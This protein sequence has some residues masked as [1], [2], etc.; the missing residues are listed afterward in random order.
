M[1]NLVTYPSLHRPNGKWSRLF[2][3]LAVMALVAGLFPGFTSRAQ[4]NCQKFDQTGKTVCGR[5][6]EYWNQNGG[7][8]QQ[9]Y[10]I[11]DEF[12]EKSDLDGKTYTVQYFQRAVF[13]WHPE[14]Q[15]LYDVL[16]S[17]LGKFRLDARTNA[18]RKV[19]Y[20]GG[21]ATLNGA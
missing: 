6:L 7:L 21:S 8:A 20:P 3:S 5:F 2:G 13:E 9:G 15:A 14:N 4:G 1:A 19:N 18:A 16:L 11:S 12:Q 10:P 17:Q